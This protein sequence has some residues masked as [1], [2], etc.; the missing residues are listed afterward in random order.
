MNYILSFFY[1]L[2]ISDWKWFDHFI[3]RMQFD[4]VHVNRYTRLVAN[5]EINIYN[6]TTSNGYKAM[7][8]PLETGLVNFIRL[9][10][11]KLSI[12]FTLLVSILLKTSK[13]LLT[14]SLLSI[15]KQCSAKVW[16][17]NYGRSHYYHTLVKK[18]EIS[19]LI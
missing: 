12:N 13:K 15:V 10:I 8:L 14:I 16:R 6:W 2:F 17:L 9:Q 4:K 7:N 11:R 18:M 3:D 1:A 5:D 19:E